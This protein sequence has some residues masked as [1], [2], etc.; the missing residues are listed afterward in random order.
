MCPSPSPL[1]FIYTLILFNSFLFFLRRPPFFH[2]LLR[3]RSRACYKINRNN[4]RMANNSIAFLFRSDFIRSVQF[5]KSSSLKRAV[6]PGLFGFVRGD[7]RIGRINSLP[8]DRL[9]QRPT[10]AFRSPFSLSPPS[11][12]PPPLAPTLHRLPTKQKH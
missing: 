5:F 7:R 8:I 11:S 3:T 12:L 10:F 6:Y 4:I 1:S 2:E 9:S